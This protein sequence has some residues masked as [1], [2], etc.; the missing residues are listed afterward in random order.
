MISNSIKVSKLHI[1][2]KTK[3]CTFRSYTLHVLKFGN[4]VRFQAIVGLRFNLHKSLLKAHCRG[5]D[6]VNKTIKKNRSWQPSV[7]SLYTEIH[8]NDNDLTAFI[9]ETK[10]D[11]RP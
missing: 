10:Y 6:W 8:E 7:I 9:L 4:F 1:I 2:R 5:A 11:P 3:D